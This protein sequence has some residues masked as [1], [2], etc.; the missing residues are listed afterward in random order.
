MPSCLTLCVLDP[1]VIRHQWLEHGEWLQ[2]PSEETMANLHSV[3]DTIAPNIN[4][5]LEA[6]A[7]LP[8]VALQVVELQLGGPTQPR[9]TSQEV[10][11]LKPKLPLEAATSP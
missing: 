2:Y 5:V 6:Y 3:L 4:T 11:M 10:F 1:W 8:W 7:W 9:P